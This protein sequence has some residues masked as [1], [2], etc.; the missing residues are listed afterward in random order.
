MTEICHRIL[1]FPSEATA[2]DRSGYTMYPLGYQ[3]TGFGVSELLDQKFKHV[4]ALTLGYS[5]V[6]V[7]YSNKRKVLICSI[8]FCRHSIVTCVPK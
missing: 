8:L 3:N 4:N 1:V 6:T 7:T 2:L 5:N